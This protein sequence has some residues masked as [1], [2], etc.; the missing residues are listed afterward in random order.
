MLER[1]SATSKVL[2]PEFDTPFLVLHGGGD[3]ATD[4]DISRSFYEGAKAKVCEIA[5]LLYDL[6]P[7]P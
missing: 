7:G 2:I 1:R 4:P 5:G 6:F 3:E